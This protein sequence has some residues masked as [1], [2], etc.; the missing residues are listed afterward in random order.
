MSVNFFTIAMDGIP[1]SQ[2]L[3]QWLGLSSD[4]T[5][6]E[7]QYKLCVIHNLE[8]KLV[9]DGVGIDMDKTS[10]QQTKEAQQAIKERPK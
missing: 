3:V 5:S 8:D 2:A 6:W 10:I 1:T 4:D 9:F 7:N